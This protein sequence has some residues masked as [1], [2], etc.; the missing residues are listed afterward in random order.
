[1]GGCGTYIKPEWIQC[2]RPTL[3]MRLKLW[4]F[5]EKHVSYAGPVE[6]VAYKYK[7]VFYVTKMDRF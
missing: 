7:D 6:C 5:G 3:L 2:F 4:L 1:M